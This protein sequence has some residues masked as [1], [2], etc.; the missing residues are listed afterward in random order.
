M[1]TFLKMA[2]ANTLD[3]LDNDSVVF[4]AYPDGSLMVFQK[5]SGHW[6]TTRDT[7]I[8]EPEEIWEDDVELWIA[9]T[10][11]RLEKMRREGQI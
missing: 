4:K 7:M 3:D 9:Y 8:Y 10:P 2:S 1:N 5:E 11:K 6:W